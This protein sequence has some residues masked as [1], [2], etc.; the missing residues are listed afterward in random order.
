M[1]ITIIHVM[2]FAGMGKNMVLLEALFL[3]LL[4]MVIDMQPQKVLLTLIYLT[5]MGIIKGCLM[6][7]QNNISLVNGPFDIKKISL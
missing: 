3:E 7:Y 2:L 5:Q 4:M 1:I 6:R